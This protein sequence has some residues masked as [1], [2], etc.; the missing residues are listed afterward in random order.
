[1]KRYI[2]CA[3]ATAAMLCMTLT[4]AS[5]QNDSATKDRLKRQSK[6]DRTTDVSASQLDSKTK[7]D[8]IRASELIGINIQN[9]Q[10][11][12]VGEIN[13]IVIDAKHGKIRYAAVTYGGFLGVGDKMFA[14]PFEA[15]QCQRDPDDADDYVMVLNVTQQQLEGDKGFDQDNWP[16][17]ADRTFTNQVDKRYRI[18]RN[19]KRRD[20]RVDVDVNRNGVD[21]DVDSDR[22]N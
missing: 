19:L 9:S 8:L 1:M 22:D 10:G 16:D 13:D 5:A 21:V 7:G 12:S 11:E 6:V 20:G 18:D 17:F 14:V 2:T 15:F 3:F 4:N